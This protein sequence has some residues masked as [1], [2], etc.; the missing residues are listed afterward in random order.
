MEHII[1]LSNSKKTFCLNFKRPGEILQIKIFNP[2]S[3]EKTTYYMNLINKN[4][5][6]IMPL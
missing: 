4:M 1:N 6:Y 3:L 2:N 5:K